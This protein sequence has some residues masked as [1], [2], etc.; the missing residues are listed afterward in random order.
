MLDE[1]RASISNYGNELHALLTIAE[2]KVKVSCGKDEICKKAKGQIDQA[3]S[4]LDLVERGKGGAHNFEYSQKILEDTRK[5]LQNT[6]QD[7]VK[8]E[9]KLEPAM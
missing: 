6:I 3:R 1:W 8:H 4:A 9:G 2:Q 5:K 7:L